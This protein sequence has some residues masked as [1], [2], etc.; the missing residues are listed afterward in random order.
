MPNPN[1]VTKADK[2]DI[3][4]LE[5]IKSPLCISKRSLKCFS[6]RYKF[7]QIYVHVKAAYLET[8]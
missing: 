4:V 1:L 3:A 7:Y 6:Y 8:G 2:V 5:K